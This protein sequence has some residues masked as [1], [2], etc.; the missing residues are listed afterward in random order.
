MLE[1]YGDFVIDRIEAFAME[2]GRIDYELVI[3]LRP[4]K[5]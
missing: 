1:A 4:V 3:A 5:A 2:A